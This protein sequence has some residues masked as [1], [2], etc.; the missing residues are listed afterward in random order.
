MQ[1]WIIGCNACNVEKLLR[2]CTLDDV[3][4]IRA[5]Y[6]MSNID[7]GVIVGTDNFKDPVADK[8]W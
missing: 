1:Q 7:P 8:V 6:M 4:K 2:F 3:P 5:S